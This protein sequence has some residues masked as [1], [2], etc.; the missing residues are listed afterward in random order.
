M[1]PSRSQVLDGALD[2]AG[3][4]G[5][6]ADALAIV[7]VPEA[8]SF[9]VLDAIDAVRS[10]PWA[11]LPRSMTPTGWSIF[12]CTIDAARI[13]FGRWAVAEGRGPRIFLF[14]RDGLRVR[15]IGAP[16]SGELN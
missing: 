2:F 13:A 3:W 14:E 10:D 12:L 11:A 5:I 15:E 4:L 9:R 8:H 6:D 1:T 16:S 7:H